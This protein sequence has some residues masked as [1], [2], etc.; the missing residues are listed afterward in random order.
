MQRLVACHSRNLALK[1]KPAQV[2]SRD[3]YGCPPGMA[4]SVAR[5]PLSLDIHLVEELAESA[6]V[7][8]LGCHW[9]ATLS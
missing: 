5:M 9:V 8:S 4:A 6:V 3:L 1:G 2:D 7:D